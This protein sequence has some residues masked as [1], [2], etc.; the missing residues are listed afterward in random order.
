MEIVDG[1][2]PRFPRAPRWARD[3][4]YEQRV[5]E[6][7]RVRE[8]AAAR[9]DLDPGVLCSR[10]RLEAIARAQPRTQEELAAVPGLRKWQIRALGPD[11]LERL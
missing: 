2:L 1:E 9:L 8:S 11:L 4:G 3:A 10:D 6:L 7:R 5:D